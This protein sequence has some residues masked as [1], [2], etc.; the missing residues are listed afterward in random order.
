MMCIDCKAK[1]TKKS[2]IHLNE[3]LFVVWP[4]T[5]KHNEGYTKTKKPA[6]FKSEVSRV[7]HHITLIEVEHQPGAKARNGE[8]LLNCHATQEN[9]VEHV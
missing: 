8:A 9:L 4:K 3:N 5:I 1:L 7:K 2:D 6:S